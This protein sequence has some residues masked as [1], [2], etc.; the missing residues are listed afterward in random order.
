MD[1]RA[2]RGR[3]IAIMTMIHDMDEVEEEAPL[4]LILDEAWE[5]HHM[6]EIALAREIQEAWYHQIN[7]SVTQPIHLRVL[8]FVPCSFGSMLQTVGI[9]SIIER[10]Q[11]I[12]LVKADVEEMDVSRLI[13]CIPK[14]KALEFHSETLQ[15]TQAILDSLIPHQESLIH[16]SVVRS[17]CADSDSMKNIFK[18][19][20]PIVSGKLQALE[21]DFCVSSDEAVSS[22]V[23][24]LQNLKLTGL[25]SFTITLTGRDSRNS[26]QT[27]HHLARFVRNIQSSKVA[28][29]FSIQEMPRLF[30]SVQRLEPIDDLV[31]AFHAKPPLEFFVGDVGLTSESIGEI[32]KIGNT[33]HSPNSFLGI[34]E[35]ALLEGSMLQALCL[36]LPSIKVRNLSLVDKKPTSDWSEKEKEA[37][38]GAIHTNTSIYHLHCRFGQCPQTPVALSQIKLQPIFDRNKCIDLTR[39][40]SHK[41]IA[42][43]LWPKLLEIFGK[44]ELGHTPT[45]LFLQ[46][47]LWSS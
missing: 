23:D 13:Q 39:I 26:Q 43:P 15:G 25:T 41:K 3:K 45:Y 12:D 37:I 2:I 31:H 14:L 35:E 6:D 1:G 18:G 11:V 20:A 36:H 21:L 24:Q 34:M 46:S 4:E 40:D 17:T 28:M 47:H 30:S 38:L 19:M 16:L 5:D 33:M 8:A 32:C 44:E 27:L 10:I 29:K 9:Q 7:P 42:L 22:L